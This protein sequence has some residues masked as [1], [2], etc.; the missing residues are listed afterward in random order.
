MHALVEDFFHMHSNTLIRIVCF[1][2]E[3]E[4]L[5]ELMLPKHILI[6]NVKLELHMLR[7]SLCLTSISKS[8]VDKW[9]MNGAEASWSQLL[10]VSRTM[11]HLEPVP[12]SL[13]PLAYSNNGKVL[14]E[15][16]IY[17]V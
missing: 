13:M 11:I 8:H 6:E 17:F 15:Y 10:S 9:V 5:Y 2:V 1:S 16:Q 4:K 3:S 7:E 12:Y 14:F